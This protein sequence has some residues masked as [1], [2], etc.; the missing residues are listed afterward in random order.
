MDS[1]SHIAVLADSTELLVYILP[2]IGSV[3]LFY[4]IFQVLSE[5]KTSTRKRMQ[6]RLR[7]ERNDNDKIAASILRR[8][9]MDDTKHFADAVVGKFKFVPKL[10]T[11]LDQAELDWSASQTLLNLCGIS[12]LVAVGLFM[13]G[14]GIVVS[15]F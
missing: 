3:L 4:G 12:L 7:G 2:L 9:A 10:Q 6:D 5:S 14:A 8:G 1:L 15:L 13:I 11:L